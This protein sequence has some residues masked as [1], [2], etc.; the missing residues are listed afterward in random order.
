MVFL[1]KTFHIPRSESYLKQ[2]YWLYT[3]KTLHLDNPSTFTEKIQ[4]LKLYVNNTPICTKMVDKYEVK[5]YVAELLS[6]KGINNLNFI[7]T[8]G[9]W[10]NFDEINFDELPDKFVLKTTHD[11]GGVVVCKDKE[12]FDIKAARKK[13]ESHLRVNYYWGGR[14]LL[15][16]DVPPRVIA[17]KF[18]VDESGEELK[19]YKIYCFD[20][21]PTI[22][23]LVTDRFNN[24]GLPPKFTYYDMNLRML[25]LSKK[26]HER[27]YN[28]PIIPNWEKMKFL[29]SV[30]SEGFPHLRVD[31]YN[32]NG[33]IFFG[34]LTFHPD[35]GV[36][37]FVPE[38]WDKKL[39]DMIIL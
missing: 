34:E 5:E 25:P 35:G 31:F 33:E 32:I 39:G 8:I 10:N 30:L 12:H 14:E 17:E 16:K 19:D 22:L 18:M 27:N 4:Y 28:P 20:G 6:N 38:E 37:P 36:V 29:A 9:V 15:Y 1:S 21:K 13:I 24:S 23:L 7:P 2:L 11:S 26:G 3:G